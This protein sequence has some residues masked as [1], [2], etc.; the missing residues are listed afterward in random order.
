[1]AEWLKAAPCLGV[2]GVNSSIE[3]SNPSFSARVGEQS[4]P[5]V[6][7]PRGLVRETLPRVTV[8]LG[9]DLLV[10]ALLYG[11][12]L[13]AQ[14]RYATVGA[15]RVAN[16]TYDQPLVAR[17]AIAFAVWLVFMTGLYLFAHGVR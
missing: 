4:F 3:G 1:M 12:S 10:L 5:H 11:Y 7:F 8:V 17:N 6:H 15:S 13:A 14:P 2:M 9:L 16:W